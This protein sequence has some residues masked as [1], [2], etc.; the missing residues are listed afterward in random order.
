MANL[1]DL[2]Q[3]AGWPTASARDWKDSPGMATEAVNPDGSVRSRLDQLPRVAVLAGWPTCRA[4]EGEKNVCSLDGA[5][6]EMAMKGGP[7]D[8]A[9]AAAIIGPMRLTARGELLTGSIAGMESGGQLNPEHSR[10]LMGYPP[11][12]CDCAVTAMQSFRRRRQSS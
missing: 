9:Q 1:N 5:L 7:Q 3:L 8:L 2:V 10:W 4:A 6:R 12:W 11:E